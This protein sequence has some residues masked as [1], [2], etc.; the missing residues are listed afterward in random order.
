[1]ENLTNKRNTSKEKKKENRGFPYK[2]RNGQRKYEIIDE[3]GKSYGEFVYRSNALKEIERLKKELFIE[4]LM[5][6]HLE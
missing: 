3:S 1:M 5:L 6:E 4:E 2:C